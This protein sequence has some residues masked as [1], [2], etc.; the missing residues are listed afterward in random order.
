MSATAATGAAA[1]RPAY[2]D[3]NVLRWLT[4]YIASML[5]DSVYF[6]A[7][8]FAAAK[9]AP[10]AQVGL[11]MAAGAVPRAVLMLGGGVVADRFGPRLVV[12]G[13]DT[14]R[15]GL[16]L[17]AAAALALASPGL[18]LLVALALV[19][20]VVDALFMPAV[21]ALP[22]RITTPD[23]LVRLQ[24][25][26]AM[27]IRVG[28]VVGPPAGGLA[29]GIGGAAA[30]F[31]VAGLLFAT[32]VPLLVGTRI[33]PQPP[34]ERAPAAQELRDGLRYIRRH[35]IVGP[36]VLSGAMCELGLVGPLNVGM[37][38]L[39]DQRGWGAAGYGWVIAAF[40][41]GSGASAVLLAVRGGIP[42]AGAVQI[43]TLLLG[44]AAVGF[45]GVAPVLGA[46]VAVAF[47]AG[48]IC[49]ICGGLATSLIQSATDPAY[50][51][52]VTSVMS[53]T[54]FGLAPLAY[55]LVASCVGAYGASPVFLV[56]AAF[57]ALG[58][59]LTAFRPSI[60]HAELP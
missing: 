10:P 43:T 13:S 48:L 4:A 19:F 37:V 50:L 27:A 38:L 47:L 9:V 16:I 28:T 32:S 12:I 15:C 59:A 2:R 5:G 45:I 23:Q 41:A 52:R 30:A 56:S 31:A 3:S 44:S 25:L 40:G 34:A 39:C 36:L 54:G 1:G 58:G 29:M 33:T 46:A 17:A 24:G 7:L 53:L 35:R 22:P 51:G 26:R 21:G 6:V 55:P 11:V 42:R 14:V 18:W 8:G 57:S 20:G 60:R 49:G